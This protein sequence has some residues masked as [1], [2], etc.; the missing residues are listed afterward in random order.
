M[1]WKLLFNYVL[2]LQETRENTVEEL[3][4]DYVRKHVRSAQHEV[5][6]TLIY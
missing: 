6:V 5:V 3:G 2:C 4:R 1:C